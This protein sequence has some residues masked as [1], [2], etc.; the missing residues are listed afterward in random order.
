MKIPRFFATLGVL[1]FVQQASAS[2]ID[3]GDFE[4][5]IQQ[6]W[7][8][9]S[10]NGIASFSADTANA[11]SGNTALKVQVQ[12][13]NSPL[14][15]V[16][17]TNVSFHKSKHNQFLVRFWAKSDA[18]MSDIMV[19]YGEGNNRQTVR[20]RLRPW[21]HLYHLPFK[22]SGD[23]LELTFHFE[24][25][26]TYYIDGVEIL[27]QDNG[28]IDVKNTLIWNENYAD[29][30]GWIAGD[31]DISVDLPDGRKMWLFNDSF[32][33]WNKADD[34]VFNSS[35]ARFL[36]NAMVIQE[37]DNKLYSYW[38]GDQ[39]S[40]SRYFDSIDPSPNENDNFY[41]LG[42]AI[43]NPT[44]NRIQVYL[45]D[46]YDT[47]GGYA[48]SSGR[49]YIA[50]FSYPGL[51]FLGIE[52]QAEIGV[53]YEDFFID[54]DYIYL[55]SHTNPQQWVYHTHVARCAL[56]DLKGY[57]GTW[58]FFD[59]QDWVP[60][61]AQ[62][63]TV[64]EFTAEGF[65]KL[66]PGNYAAVSHPPVSG[67]LTVAFA[68]RPEGPWTKPKDL[69]R[70]PQ[71]TNYWSYMSNVHGQLENGNYSVSYSTNAWNEGWA[72]V[73]SD[74]YW[75]RQ[76]FVQA[77]LL[78]MS[79]Y[80]Y[81]Q[82]NIALQQA[83]SASSSESAHPANYAVDGNPNTRWSSEYSDDQWLTVD[84]GQYHR[85]DGVK[86]TW[87][88]ARARDYVI[89]ASNDGQTWSLVKTVLHNTENVNINTGLEGYGRYVRIK[90]L[91]R[92]SW[93]G[94]SIYEM[95]VYGEVVARRNLALKR[96]VQ[97]SSQQDAHRAGWATDGNPNTRWSSEYSDDQWLSVDLG[98]KYL[99]DE[100]RIE[101]EVARALNYD[102]EVSLDGLNWT[103]A[104]AVRGNQ[105]TTNVLG[106]IQREARY[107]RM[108]G[109]N[110]A[111]IWG[112][113]IYELEVYGQAAT[114]PSFAKKVEAESFGNNLGVQTES[115]SDLGGGLN[116]GWL[117]PG[118][119]M[120]Y[121]DIN[122]PEAGTYTVEY[123]VAGFAE[124]GTLV[125]DLNAGAQVLG[126]VSIP[127]TSGDQNWTT[128]SH[129]VQLEAGTYNFGI[130]VPTGGWNINWWRISK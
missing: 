130:Y 117:D 45:I 102:L 107:V 13:A 62:A 4:A 64:G 78:G 119:W 109:I 111:T 9:T 2:L 59:G 90:G 112:Y 61:R 94:Y 7:S 40:T 124:G 123:R 29:G 36:R 77:D 70:I 23:R 57:K 88:N 103:Q 27:D 28:E 98:A 114:G 67:K 22:Y 129:Q 39:N 120:A 25:A 127:M 108:K 42:E 82:Q 11:E 3:N 66:Q 48:D 96:N 38:S 55:F 122:I 6:S 65:V 87:E 63:A 105:D 18:D 56:D 47:G 86:L 49:S 60:D 17:S 116:V 46:V 19:S 74:K 106:D 121:F 37:K 21:S 72:T 33:G 24:K 125:L 30:F 73:W 8:H 126:E 51:E 128:V 5:G 69:Y 54:G 15:A 92:A 14:D 83:V 1:F 79:P 50:E 52:R 113:S 20:Y 81:A 80:T 76:R 93:W 110:R 91:K 85:I 12:Q 44:L 43:Y 26:T 97:W 53:G 71:E 89:E 41:W 32:Y 100:V 95:E 101:W 99:V 10:A 34:N 58:R 118:D 35:G 84:L 68:E 75:Y 115:T 104:R 31:N 16:T